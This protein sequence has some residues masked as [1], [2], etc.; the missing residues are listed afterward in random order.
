[1]RFFGRLLLF[2]LPQTAVSTVAILAYVRAGIFPPFGVG[3]HVALVLVL[4]ILFFT[5]WALLGRRLEGADR[6]WFR[7][8]YALSLFA[9][10][11]M[12]N[13]V[14]AASYASYSLWAE[15]I[16]W[17][18]LRALGSHLRG[19]QLA[20]G[21]GFLLALAAL[22]LAL[23]GC[24][25][26]LLGTAEKSL[27]RL[28]MT[29]APR[30]AALH[31]LLLAAL[32]AVAAANFWFRDPLWLHMADRDPVLAFW[33]NRAAAEPVLTAEML[34]DRA[35]SRAYVVPAEFR[36]RNVIVIAIDCL[37]ADHLSFR[38]YERETMPH[39]ASLHGAGRLHEVTFGVS[40]GN[41]SPQGIRAIL[42]SRLPH[43][44]NFHNFRLHDLLRQAGY[45]THMFGTGDHTTL[46]NMR[47]HYGPNLDV[48]RDGLSSRQFSVNDD[49]GLIESLDEL[50][51]ADSQ[52]AFFYIH[53]MSAHELGV[54]EPRFA[55][56]Q[57]ASLTMDWHAIIT[58]RHDPQ[59]TVNSYDNGVL[60]ADHHL[61]EI[62]ARL[63]AK[64]YM[65]DYV[66]VI[67]GDHGQGLGDRGHHGHS[68]FLHGQDV[69][70][71][72]L[73]LESGAA[74]YGPMPFGSHVDIAPTLLDRLGL[75]KPARWQGRS[76]YGAA[77]PESTFLVAAR[78]GSWRGVLL[79]R[80]ER[81]SKYLFKG[82]RAES[83][84]EELYD[85]SRD[86]GETRNLV[87]DPASAEL[88][89]EMR[90]MA[91]MEFGRPV[92]PQN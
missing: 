64:G 3:T 49:R 31:G 43:R 90:R 62:L 68:E 58:K 40:N 50:P 89:L 12:L 83:F 26:L 21:G 5:G 34:A 37:R 36:R 82:I 73:F 18:N 76:L 63:E 14:Y 51:A 88:L 41:D 84:Q 56:W 16:S 35:E 4:Q 91:A 32:A 1:M 7:R 27:R 33:T 42:N 92:P 69:N 57:P 8:L 22:A 25:W 20:I 85:L 45:R 44:Q 23:A 75:P 46:G 54:R 52:P 28:Q 6:P 65:R 2:C 24:L 48:F 66:A 86:P 10:G 70:V 15:Y 71:P 79:R 53:L 77:P 60:Q 67:T 72:I 30:A 81:L 59:A 29:F 61:R 74:T 47:L 9:K 39:L 13:L 38:G 19:F 80:E 78:S 87:A 17:A 55:R 11:L